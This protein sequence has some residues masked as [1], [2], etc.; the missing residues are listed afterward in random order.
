M[1]MTDTPK[2]GVVMVPVESNR[3][4]TVVPVDLG[5]TGVAY[6]ESQLEKAGPL[7]A[8]VAQQIIGQ[9]SSFTALEK[10]ETLESALQ[11]RTGTFRPIGVQTAS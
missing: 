4:A 11:F 5:Q 8:L 3:P 10:G 9:G 2:V 7:A 6:V 1:T